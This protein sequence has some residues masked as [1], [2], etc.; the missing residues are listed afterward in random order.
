M[1]DYIQ[2]PNDSK[3]QIPGPKSDQHFDRFT[4]PLAF[5][6]SKQPTYIQVVSN[7]GGGL[8]LFFGSSASFAAKAVTESGSANGY[9]LTASHHYETFDTLAA[10]QYHLN[11]I[12]VSGSAADVAKIKFVYKGGLDGLGRP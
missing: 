4:S 2:D 6:Q 3:K 8:G 7:V 10:G 11:P 12:A 9:V 1:P 5:T